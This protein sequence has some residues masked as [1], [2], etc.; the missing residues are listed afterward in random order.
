MEYRR[1]ILRLLSNGL[2]GQYRPTCV[3]S[4]SN[5]SEFL[6]NGNGVKEGGILSPLLFNVYMDNLSIQLHRQS[7]G[8]TLVWVVL[9]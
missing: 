3:R 2:I 4:G 7:I 5:H 1:L 6:L 9:S 8:C